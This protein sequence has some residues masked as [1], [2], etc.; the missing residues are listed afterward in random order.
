MKPIN[1]KLLSPQMPRRASGGG[2]PRGVAIFS[3]L[4][5]ALVP[6]IALAAD[7]SESTATKAAEPDFTSLSLEDLGEIKMPSV[8][9]AS[10]HE[11]RMADAPASVS[12][13][14]A[15]DIQQYGYRTLADILNSVRGFY[16]TSDRTYN[17]LGVRGFNRPGDYGGRNLLLVDGHRMN[18]ALFDTTSYGHDF[19]LDVNLIDRV[20]VVRGPGSTLYGNN[21]FFSVVNVIPKRGQDYNWGEVSVGGGNFESYQGRFT[22]G[23]Q[24]T[25]GLEFLFSGSY[26]DSQGEE[27]I[28]Y[29]SADP[30]HPLPNGGVAVNRDYER[31]YSVFGQ[32]R[33]LDFTLS[34]A[35]NSREKA[36][37]TAPYFSSGAVFN[38]SQAVNTD[39]PAYVDLKFERQF[40]DDWSLL[41]RVGYNYYAYHAPA[42]FDYGFTG[43]PADYTV[44]YDQ[45]RSQALG[46]EV[47]VG[48]TLFERHQIT[49]GAEYRDL[50]ENFYQNQDLNPATIYTSINPHQNS[51][52]VFANAEVQLYRTN[53]LLHAGLR[54]DG[55]SEFDPALSPR[56]ALIAHPWATTTLRFNYGQAYRTPNVYESV[57]NSLPGNGGGDAPAPETI[58]SYEVAWEQDIGKHFRSTVVGYLNQIH[59]LIDNDPAQARLVNLG[60]VE[61]RGLEFELEGHGRSGLRGRVSYALQETR[62]TV[63]N[64]KLSNSPE[65][66]AKL[67]FVLPLYRDKMFAGFEVQYH[68]A[69]TS[70]YDT[71]VQDFWLLNVTLFTQKIVKGLE[72]SASVQNLLDEEYAFPANTRQV[73]AELPQPGRTLWFKLTYKF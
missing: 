49:F 56:A 21:A 73:Q 41:A 7:G 35:F 42:Q 14:T 25:K 2:G 43:N 54:Y 33:Y 20:E 61:S 62:D 53:L 23:K 26:Y 67:S 55:F 65:H 48:K 11:E 34:G 12:V 6:V 29:V 9:S 72:F 31:A 13:V 4:A 3:L 17:F 45:M 24:L 5:C 19:G 63:T 64:R 30:A 69:V 68:G 39:E 58:R 32:V 51:W 16:V 28:K 27:K 46:G 57:F 10:K 40:A 18:E 59:D 60:D 15:E 47:Q 71:Q 1:R 66:L 22:V 8:Y 70:L 52:G 50:F 44:N 38:D 36:A 37:S